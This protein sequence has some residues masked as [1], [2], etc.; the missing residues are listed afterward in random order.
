GVNVMVLPF[1]TSVA[2]AT[3]EAVAAATACT[4]TDR[5]TVPAGVPVELTSASVYVD[6]ELEVAV[7]AVE[8]WSKPSFVPTGRSKLN[9]GPIMRHRG[10]TAQSPPVTLYVKVTVFPFVTVDALAVKV[11]M[12]GTATPLTLV[13]PVANVA[14]G[15]ASFWT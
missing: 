6:V 11:A 8:T 2:F 13:A 4:A 12:A 9:D 1:A 10:A 5:D 15:V 7:A 3:S 14:M